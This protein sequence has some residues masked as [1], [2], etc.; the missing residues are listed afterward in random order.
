M[1]Q[2]TGN[3]ILDMAEDRTMLIPRSTRPFTRHFMLVAMS[4]FATEPAAAS[5]I[6]TGHLTSDGTAV[7]SGDPVITNPS[8]IHAGD[9]FSATLTFDPTQYMSAGSSYVLTS[10]SLA[11]RF[12]GYTFLYNAGAYF[13]FAS[14]GVYGSGTVSFQFCSSQANCSTNDFINLYYNGPLVNPGNLASNAGSFTGQASASPAEFE[15]LRSFSSDGSQTDLQGTLGPVIVTPE[16]A[17]LATVVLSALLAGSARAL[18][19]RSA[20]S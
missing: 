1:K 17:T 19:G 12:D 18:R 10:A 7:G 16:P 14:P 20:A 8:T 11:L 6:F 5:I 9:A 2:N 4:V 13:E 15:F 3:G